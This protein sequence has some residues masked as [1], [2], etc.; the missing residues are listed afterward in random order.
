MVLSRNGAGIIYD[1]CF[2]GVRI[3]VGQKSLE[4]RSC[5]LAGKTLIS[6]LNVDAV[7]GVTATG[8]V[9]SKTITEKIDDGCR[10]D[11]LPA[12]TTHTV[13]F[14][15]SFFITSLHTISTNLSPSTYF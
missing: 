8:I 3:Y 9:N 2:V 6:D 11:T 5:F 13:V 7:K 15:N 14:Q 4:S 12:N 1:S 10:I